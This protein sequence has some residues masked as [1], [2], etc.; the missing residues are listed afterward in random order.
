MP[1]RVTMA[2]YSYKPKEITH[3]V[4]IGSSCYTLFSDVYS[5]LNYTC[6]QAGGVC[7]IFGSELSHR[8]LSDTV[9]DVYYRPPEQEE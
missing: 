3:Y 1:I 4:L 2:T 6:S 5:F 8:S 9:V 7:S